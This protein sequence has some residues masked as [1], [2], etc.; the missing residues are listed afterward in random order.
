VDDIMGLYGPALEVRG[1]LGPRKSHLWFANPTNGAVIAD[2]E[3]L[4]LELTE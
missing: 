1:P 4:P 2:V 3:D